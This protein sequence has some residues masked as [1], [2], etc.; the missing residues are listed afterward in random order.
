MAKPVKPRRPYRSERRREQAQQTRRRILDAAHRLF[1]E[2]G[3]S[4]TTI[5]AV[6]T[7][8]G[9]AAETVYAIFGSKPGLLADLVSAAVR[10]DESTPVQEQSGPAAVRAATDQR[11]QLR[12]FANDI[13]RRLERVGPLMT[14]LATEARSE[15]AL[16]DLYQELHRTRLRGLRIL[17]DALRANGPLRLDVDRATEAVWALASPEL[18]VLLTRTRGWARAAYVD[19]L[20]E[21]LSALLLEPGKPAGR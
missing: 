1:V 8:A 20:A 3:F 14:V 15:P 13:V 5:A 4:G 6:A 10:G 12:L 18:H 9:T 11:E 2:R 16:D 21:S 19:W 7:E 17:T